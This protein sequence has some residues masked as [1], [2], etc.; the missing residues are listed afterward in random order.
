MV[1]VKQGILNGTLREVYLQSQRRSKRKQRE[2]KRTVRVSELL[3]Q[4][5]RP[6]V[7]AKKGS[8][9]LYTAHSSAMGQ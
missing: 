5:A 1:K 9:S 8:V 7:G 6:S 2:F 4:P 3:R